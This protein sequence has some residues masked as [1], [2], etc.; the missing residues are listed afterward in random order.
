MRR[1][2]YNLKY[3]CWGLEACISIATVLI[4]LVTRSSRSLKCTLNFT[5]NHVKG[6]SVFLFNF[7]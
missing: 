3:V 7:S 5:E 1:S 4:S 6:G 2:K